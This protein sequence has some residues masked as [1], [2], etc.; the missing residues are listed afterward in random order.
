MAKGFEIPD[1]VVGRQDQHLRLRTVTMGDVERRHR[2]RRRRI[3]P[4]RLEQEARVG[5]GDQSP[6]LVATDE[7][8]IAR[9]HGDHFLGAARPLARGAACA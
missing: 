4:Y 5:L 1:Q 6:V 8:V 9:G 2:D 7:V 3:A